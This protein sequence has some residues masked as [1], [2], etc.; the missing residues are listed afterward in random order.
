M[1]IEINTMTMQFLVEVGKFAMGELRE[2]WKLH[3]KTSKPES[4]LEMDLS[5]EDEVK[6]R[7]PV[8]VKEL[9][10]NRDEKELER[11]IQLMEKKKNL[12][13]QWRQRKLDNLEAHNL[14]DLPLDTLNL[15]NG[16][17]DNRITSM[18]DEIESDLRA[19][20]IIVDRE[21]AI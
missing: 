9:S 16:S 3:R 8:L 21:K 14:G 18:A 6:E 15:R 20:G 17:L 10:E 5:N 1:T 7:T 12:I 11:V 2:R 4:N 19:V 13:F